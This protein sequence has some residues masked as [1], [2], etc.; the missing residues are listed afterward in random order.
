MLYLYEFVDNESLSL[1]RARQTHIVTICHKSVTYIFSSYH[2]PHRRQGLE[3]ACERS[4]W[5][6]GT[7]SYSIH[8]TLTHFEVFGSAGLGVVR[9]LNEAI[10]S[11]TMVRLF[12]VS[13]S[14]RL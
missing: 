10:Q 9:R 13:V 3:R 2:H 5:A 8:C 4:E 1:P 12:F 11:S 6:I 7:F 14:L